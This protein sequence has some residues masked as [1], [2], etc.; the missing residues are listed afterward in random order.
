MLFILKIIF[1]LFLLGLVITIFEKVTGINITGDS[2]SGVERPEEKVLSPL[3]KELEEIKPGVFG[4]TKKIINYIIQFYKQPYVNMG[5]SWSSAS[6]ET[7]ISKYID[8]QLLF[9]EK[10]EEHVI[11]LAGNVETIGKD[12]EN[13]YLSIG[14]S[15]YYH[16]S[17]TSGEGVKQLIKCYISRPDFEDDDYKNLVLNMRP[18]AE[19]VLVGV[20]VK[21]RMYRNTFE[22]RGTTLIEVNGVVPNRIMSI[23]VN[24]I[25]RKYEA[26]KNEI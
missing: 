23:V 9:S 8:N 25:Y 19:V 1:F 14:D 5:D 12:G 10:Y 4:R 17:G 18:G 16:R 22:L 13:V 7:I 20:L 2:E 26:E 24:S 15:S 3:E 11:D 6:I 21:G